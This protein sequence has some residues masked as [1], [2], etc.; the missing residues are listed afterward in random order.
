MLLGALSR[1]EGVFCWIVAL[2]EKYTHIVWFT[3]MAVTFRIPTHKAH[4]TQHIS[5]RQT[6]TQT[7][8]HNNYLDKN[9][10]NANACFLVWYATRAKAELCVDRG[11]VVQLWCIWWNRIRRHLS[12]RERESSASADGEEAKT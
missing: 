6:H 5:I 2:C 10:A 8:T 12:K 9:D 4:N 11:F 1:W 3:T 7:H